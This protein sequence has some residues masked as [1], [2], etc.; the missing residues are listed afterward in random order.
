[1]F[2]SVRFIKPNIPFDPAFSESCPTPIFRRCFELAEMNKTILRICSLGIGYARINGSLV[3]EDLFTAPVSDYQKTLWVCEYDVTSLLRKGKNVITV[4]C[5]NGF[6]N[7]NCKTSWK[8]NDAPW[9]D[10][11]KTALTLSSDGECILTTDEAWKCLPHTAIIF[12]EL[13]LGEYYDARLD[14]ENVHAVEYDD[15]VWASAAVDLTPLTGRFLLCPSEPIRATAVYPSIGVR[16]N[17]LG[18]WVF[19]IGQNISGFGRLTVKLPAGTQLK[20][21]YAE[22]VTDEGLLDNN[23][24]AEHYKD[25]AFMTEKVICRDGITTHEA[26]FAY[27]GFRYAELEGWPEDALSPSTETFAGVFVHQDI[28]VGAE[29]ASS[30]ENLNRLYYIGRMA[31]YSNFFNMP[32]DC[33]TREK[34]G[35]ANDAQSSMASFLTNHRSERFMAKWFIDICDAMREDGAMPGIIPTAGWGYEWG[36]GPVSDGVLFELPYRV[37][38]NTGE[39]GLLYYGLPF[40]VRYLAHLDS[41]RDERGMI[42]FGL[43]DWT[44]PKKEYADTAPRDLINMALEC[45]MRGI[46][47]LAL[48]LAAGGAHTMAAG[49][50]DTVYALFRD[51]E[52]AAVE[53]ACAHLAEAERTYDALRERYIRA[54]IGEDGRCVSNCQTAVAMTISLGLYRE[55]APLKTQLTERLAYRRFHHE[56]G[57]AGMPH[58]FRALHICGLDEY[59]Y[60]IL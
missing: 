43:D 26:R 5:G 44:P 14:D 1:M 40:F 2:E 39:S 11:P 31:Q 52:P 45:K 7:E 3:S 10:H 50:Q 47:R 37:W 19:D 32:T 51:T 55:L 34:L 18:R 15:S 9:R 22:L 56:C 59:A 57:M 16:K 33:P 54:W 58:L 6:Y 49:G 42:P 28:P 17:T 36:N 24:M 46:L 35:W 13:R 38:L 29:F 8:F 30:D 48:R 20:L 60:Q 4:Q 23:R 12:Q 41:S 27:Y 53:Y 21:R 25:G